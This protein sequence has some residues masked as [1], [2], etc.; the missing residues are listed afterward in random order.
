LICGGN[1]DGFRNLFNDVYKYFTPSIYILF[2]FIV[3]HNISED[4]KYKTHEHYMIENRIYSYVSCPF[5]ASNT[6]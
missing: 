5:G 1:R 3:F 2:K 4:K 6:R